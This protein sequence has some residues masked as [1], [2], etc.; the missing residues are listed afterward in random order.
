MH[1]GGAGFG[2][3][4]AEQ[5]VLESS[6]GE[7]QKLDRCCGCSAGQRA[8]AGALPSTVHNGGA[9][10]ENGDG[11]GVTRLTVSRGTG[12]RLNVFGDQDAASAL[13]LDKRM[14]NGPVEHAFSSLT[15]K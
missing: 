5:V 14:V 2:F 10:E 11:R 13:I 9:T 12:R 8:E 7:V 3:G 15:P 4:H 1:R 6:Q